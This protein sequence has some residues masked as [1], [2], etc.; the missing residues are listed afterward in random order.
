MIKYTPFIFIIIV[1]FILR[2]RGGEIANEVESPNLLRISIF[3]GFNPIKSP[4]MINKVLVYRKFSPM[5]DEQKLM[6]HTLVKN[7]WNVNSY[8]ARNKTPLILSSVKLDVRAVEL[9]LEHGA[10]P[11]LM[12]ADG[13]PALLYICN[14]SGVEAETI[15]DLL[16]KSGANFNVIGS[17]GI[18]CR[19]IAEIHYEGRKRDNS[20]RRMFEIMDLY[21]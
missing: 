6:I 19:D 1:L 18:K 3:L 9:L 20:S 7:G 14:Q 5:N 17:R 8:D 16:G 2:S 15:L 10:N 21:D 13:D 12:D 4:D 11:D